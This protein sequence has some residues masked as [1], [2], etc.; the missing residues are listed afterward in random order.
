[1][2]RDERADIR[3]P[4]AM[5]PLKNQRHELFCQT[6]VKGAKNGMSQ[7]SAY[8][9]SG[10]KADDAAARANAARL[11]ATDSIRA[12][13]AELTAP[14]VKKTRTTIDTLAQQFD[15]VFDAAM[16][17]TQLGAAGAAAAA[18]AKLLGFM[19]DRLEVGGVGS[20]DACTTIEE[21]AAAL[22][23]DQ[24]PAEAL[25]TLDELR[26][27]VELCALTRAAVVGAP[28][29]PVDELSRSIAVHRPGRKNGRGTY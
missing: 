10:Y 7:A 6:L 23:A 13:L 28:L 8:Q 18:K 25:Q 21:A 19:R 3:Y 12:R 16:S 26:E 17:N 22:L 15:A 5:A 2:T 27:A 29:P 20:F 24:S 1:V 4:H 11:I 9:R 14:T